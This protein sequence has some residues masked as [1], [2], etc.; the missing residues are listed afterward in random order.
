MNSGFRIVLIAQ[1][2]L[3]CM[4]G[5]QSPESQ[6]A[7]PADITVTLGTAKGVIRPLLGV[8]AGPM[9]AGAQSNAD[10]TEGYQWIGVTQIRTHN[11]YGPL[12]MATMFPDQNADPSNPSSYDFTESDKVFEAILAGGFEPYLRLGDSWRSGFGFPKAEL[13]A[14]SKRA[15]WVRAAVEVVRHYRRMAGSCLRYVEIWNEP[16]LRQ[17]WDAQLWSF[18]PLFD[19]TARALKTAFPDLKVGGPG[20][21]QAAVLTPQGRNLTSTFLRYLKRHSTPLDFFSWHMYANNP[22]V[23]VHAA[24]F[25]RAELNRHGFSSTESHLTEYNTDERQPVSVMDMR[26]GGHGAAVITAAWIG[27]QQEDV[28]VA[29]FYRGTDPAMDL[30]TFF[31][32]FRANGTPKRAALAFSFWSQIAKHPARLRLTTTDRDGAEQIWLLAGKNDSGEIAVLAANPHQSDIMWEI[33]DIAGRAV[34]N[35]TVREINDSSAGI[36]NRTIVGN[37][38]VI[39]G[40]TVQLVTFNPK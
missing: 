11:Y 7:T 23:F 4:C 22:S 24:Q 16:D 28:A 12:D 18:F 5:A 1:F 19:E 33:A 27:L 30:P 34:T 14:P 20:F 26:M 3:A 35:L 17:F 29:A 32:L 9:A 13:R 39:C 15:N 6:L 36:V 31:G 37:A 2:M 40:Y 8:N 10:V 25:Y 38:L 21:T